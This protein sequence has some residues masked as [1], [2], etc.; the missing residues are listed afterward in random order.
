MKKVNN[1]TTKTRETEVVDYT[2]VLLDTTADM[3]VTIMTN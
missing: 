1:I 2:D 3:L